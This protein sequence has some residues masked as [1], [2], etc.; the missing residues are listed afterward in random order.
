MT[1]AFEALL[2][3]VK[4]VGGVV[5]EFDLKDEANVLRMGRPPKVVKDL[6]PLKVVV[7]T[8]SSLMNITLSLLDE[9]LISSTIGDEAAS[10][11]SSSLGV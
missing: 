4:V 6:E 2:E 7:S 8:F 9:V 3:V 5:K 10:L 11:D 1:S